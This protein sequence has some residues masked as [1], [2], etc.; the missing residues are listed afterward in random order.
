MSLMKLSPESVRL[1]R[2]AKAYAAG[3]FSLREYRQARRDVIAN[4]ATQTLD[5][6][7]TQ[8]RWDTPTVKLA[9]RMQS[10]QHLQSGQVNQITQRKVNSPMLWLAM[11]ALLCVAVYAS[12]GFASTD[13]P[14]VAKRNPNPVT[15]ERLLINKIEL[16]DYAV[17]PGVTPDSIQVVI[18]AKLE[19]V[20]RRNA[21]GEHGFTK[22]EL[23]ELGRLLNALGVH[24]ATSELS[25]RDAADLTALIRQQKKRRGLSI[26]ELEEVAAAVQAHFRAT[27]YFL[28][29]AFV[30]AQSVAD[31]VVALA[32]LPG[33]LGEVIVHGGRESIVAR[34]FAD[35][36]GK[37]LTQRVISTRLYALNQASGVSAQASFEPGTRVG[38]TRLNI[39]LNEQ[40]SWAG[41]LGLDNYGDA[42]TGQQRLFLAAS[43]L[44]PTGRGDSVDLAILASVDPADQTYG[45]AEYRTPLSGQYRFRGRISNND[46]SAAEAITIDGQAQLLD[47]AVERSLHRDRKSSLAFELGVSQHSLD[48]EADLS[49][50]ADVNQRAAFLT[51]S[52]TAHRVW[53]RSHIATQ[54]ELFVAGGQ[55]SG[56]TFVGQDDQFWS[57][58]VDLFAWRPM[59]VALLPGTQ[60][61]SVRLLGQ[62]SD[63]QLPSTLRM[64][65]GGVQ[66]ARGFERS[67]YL[68][69]EGALLSIDLRTPFVFG[70]LALFADTAYGQTHNDVE[71]T[72]GHLTSV[73]IGWD[74]A[75]NRQ[76]MSRFSWALPLTAKG[77]GRLNDDGPQ[78]FWSLHYV[79]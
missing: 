43:W 22:P 45:Y 5:D 21:A 75:I 42:H 15:S 2:I 77:S 1:R 13:I 32:V 12:R 28:A 78:M 73:G 79:P 27:G 58:G 55:I 60:K 67:I 70:E 56:D 74:Y 35:L 41:R 31:G 68:A 18:D 57:A 61:L 8:P 52:L 51:G 11:F 76:L 30:P 47:L 69:D 53:D 29:V 16:R 71:S 36:I 59:D 40:R 62:F 49:G 7:D 17:L 23:E 63:S 38:E 19:E 4:F 65:F 24:D 44:N 9:D 48:W 66:R 54:A 33:V 72:W 50:F 10:T 46:F 6:D 37:P 14:P 26:F 34:R 39:E 20:R 3:E 64:G 25:R